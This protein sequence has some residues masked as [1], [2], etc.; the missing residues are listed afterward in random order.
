MPQKQ[1]NRI[2]ES[3]C[4]RKCLYPL[5]FYV[6]PVPLEEQLGVLCQN[7]YH[8]Q[9]SILRCSTAFDGI[10][11]VLFPQGVT[12]E[13]IYRGITVLTE[14]VVKDIVCYKYGL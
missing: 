11:I 1:G 4:P 7:D 2:Y 14:D 6:S 13:R 12:Y 8:T 3:I 9:H 5:C 10:S